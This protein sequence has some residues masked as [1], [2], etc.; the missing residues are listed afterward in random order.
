MTNSETNPAKNPENLEATPAA[1]FDFDLI[2]IGA[3]SGGVRAS[4]IAA[5]HGARVAVIEEDR[6]GG[7]CVLRGCVPKKLLVYGAAFSA[8]LEDALGFGWEDMNPADDWAHNWGQLITTKN[9]EL[10]RLAGIYTSLLDNAGV[11]LIEGRGRITGPHSVAVNGKTY[12]AERILVAVG[13][14]PS[15]PDI[16]G[17]KD[18]AIT[19]NEALNLN[20]R[21]DQVLVFGSG[22]IAVEFAG[23]F[24]GFGAETHLVYRADQP[25]RG[26]DQDLR[27]GFAEAAAARGIHMH[28]GVTITKVEAAGDQKKVTLSSGEVLTVDVVMAA[29]GRHPMTDDLGLEAAGVETN[30]KGAIVVDADSRSN[31]PSI[32]AIGDVTDRINL[33]P[34][35]IAEG[36]AFA[37][38]FYGQ[39]PRRP[40]HTNVAS[41]VFSMPPIGSV[42]LT[43]DDAKAK[44]MT[45]KVFVASFR[46]MKN[47]I[48]GRAEKTVM[49]LIVDPTSD[50]VIGAHMLGPDAP[51]II[52]GIAIAIKA[53]ATKADFDATIGIHPTAAEEFV[54]MRTPRD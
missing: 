48:S 37:D 2:T 28:P 3:G 33:T 14:W 24:N 20:H 17:L 47:T 19:S 6:P 30:A 13:G 7:T 18:H 35:A 16:P 42:G 1:E 22:Y 52:Q 25:L 32:F 4:R 46:A 29:T 8:D 11:T 54:T 49:K 10:D 53:G 44:G 50:V 15:V 51:E 45:P 31:I 12:T 5:S 26:F 27:D 39:N 23:I 41:A 36:H 21:P 40:D 38:T 43:E 34:V 9:K